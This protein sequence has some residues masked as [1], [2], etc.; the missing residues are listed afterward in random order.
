MFLIVSIMLLTL[1]WAPNINLCL[2]S[3]VVV[4]TSFSV[5]R[6]YC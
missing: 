3:F 6:K 1:T 5:V 4:V 2:L